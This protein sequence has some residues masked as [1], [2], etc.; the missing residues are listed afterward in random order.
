[1]LV[2]AAA[3]L[4]ELQVG[5]TVPD[6]ALTTTGGETK[7]LSELRGDKLTVVLFWSTWSVKS[8]KNLLRMEKVYQKYRDLGLAVLA[9]NA[10]DQ[11]MSDQTVAKVREVVTRLKLSYPVLLDK[12]LGAFHDVGVIALPTTV[13]LDKERVIAY[14]LSG[15][16]L[17][18]SEEMVDYIAASL[19]GKKTVLAVSKKYRPNKES[20]RLFNMGQ[21][22]L[23]AR[24]LA[25]TVEMWFKR[26]IEA[27][28]GFVQ[29]HLSLGRF[30]LQRGDVAAARG[31]FEQS[32]VKEPDNVVALCE[33]GMILA[34]EGK[35]SEGMAYFDR[36]LKLDEAYTPC[37]Y[38]S[39]LLLGR[40]GKLDEALSRFDLAVK[41]NSLDY[42]IYLYKGRLLEE[43]KKPREAA[44]SY[45][46]SL[47][48]VLNLD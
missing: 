9:V 48:R 36:S 22:T 2:P 20:Q 19:E 44:E 43:A 32:L 13:I 46:T 21:N 38:Y 11:K 45:R 26:S 30:Y 5:M 8:E 24:R 10:D 47:E 3:T 40:S 39:G 15:Y 27:D 7:K 33:L 31:Q 6:L 25:D 37:F 42:R 1:M 16:P 14:E 18:G 34:E 35:L 29:P 28:P 23:K 17:V 41:N 12:G 4:Q